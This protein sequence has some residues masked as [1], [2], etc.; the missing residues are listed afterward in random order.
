MTEGVDLKGDL[1]RFSILCKVPYLPTQ[2]PVV[3]ARMEYDQDW[4]AYKTAMTIVQ[5]PGR[6]IRTET[7]QAVTYLIDPAFQ[8][9]LRRNQHLFPAWFLDSLQKGYSGLY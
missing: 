4:Y 9:F 3:Q 7:D 5:A 1:A 2:D 6:A 8:G